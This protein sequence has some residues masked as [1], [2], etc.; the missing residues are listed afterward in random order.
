[1][2]ASY[3]TSV[4]APATK[5]PGDVIQAAHV[6]DLQTEVTAIEDGILNGTAPVTSSNLTVRGLASAAAQPR[7]ILRHGQTQSMPDGVWT[8]LNFD[9]ED[10]DVG[11]MHS[12]VSNSSRVTITSTGIYELCASV[13]FTPNSSG[14]RGLRFMKNDVTILPGVTFVLGFSNNSVGNGLALTAKHRFTTSGDYVTAQGIQIAV[15]AGLNVSDSTQAHLMSMFAV[16]REL[17]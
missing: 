17:L 9:T 4:F 8:G 12:T 10:E 7:C 1:M 16:S 6:N 3:P 14:V 5:N 15:A 11:A 2:P 13:Y